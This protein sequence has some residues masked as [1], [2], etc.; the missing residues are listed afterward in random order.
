MKPDSLELFEKKLSKISDLMSPHLIENGKLNDLGCLLVLMSAC[1]DA[2]IKAFA[3]LL[4]VPFLSDLAR[5]I[6]LTVSEV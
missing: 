3:S 5:I 6:S 4:L 1:S 2:E